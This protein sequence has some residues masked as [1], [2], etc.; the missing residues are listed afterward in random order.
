MGDT[1]T[2][3][4]IQFVFAVKYRAAMIDT[5]WDSRLRQYIT[6]IIQNDGHKLIA[7]NNMPDHIHIFIGLN[8]AKSIAQVM[9]LVKTNSSLWI[10]NEIKPRHKFNWQAGYGAFSYSRSHIDNVVKYIQNQQEHHRATNFLTEYKI[11]LDRFGVDYD[12]KY[13]FTEPE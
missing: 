9:Q 10:N 2:Q 7:I 11:M 13:L 6:G 4:Y 1:Y 3:L 5:D 12:V 8:P